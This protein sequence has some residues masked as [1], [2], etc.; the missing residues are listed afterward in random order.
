MKFIAFSSTPLSK[1][2]E[3]GPPRRMTSPLAHL[4]N[5]IRFVKRKTNAMPEPIL[6]THEK[7]IRFLKKML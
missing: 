3:L 6:L 4:E 5:P 1:E 2:M 7:L